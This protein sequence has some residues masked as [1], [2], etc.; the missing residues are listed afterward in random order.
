MAGR[1]RG[2][3]AA[4]SPAIPNVVP[5]NMPGA[6]S[7]RAA[8]HV[9]NLTARDRIDIALFAASTAVEPLMGNDQAKFDATKFGWIGS[10][11]QDI[12]FCG[13]W[14]G[15]GPADHLPRHAQAGRARS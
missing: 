9:Y 3:T 10:M 8:N 14:H 12:S 4:S 2:T 1:S 15:A 7:L 11:N 5:K 6:G 13:V